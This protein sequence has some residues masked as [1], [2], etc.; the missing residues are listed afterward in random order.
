MLVGGDT[1][2]MTEESTSLH[3]SQSRGHGVTPLRNKDDEGQR[4]RGLIQKVLTETDHQSAAHSGPVQT[5]TD[6]Y[7]PGCYTDLE[8]CHHCIHHL[9]TER[10]VGF[11]RA[12]DW[13][14]GQE[15]PENTHSVTH[16]VS[17]NRPPQSHS[18]QMSVSPS[19][20]KEAVNIGESRGELFEVA[21]E[22]RGE[23]LKGNTKLS[24]QGFKHCHRQCPLQAC[25]LISTAAKHLLDTQT[26]LV[27]Q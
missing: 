5:T 12:T 22:R 6:L 4:L 23:A 26:H 8:V 27:N 1:Q 11:K 15:G 9:F 3:A 14:E 7:R 16:T 19:R 21:V 18:S 13:R 10:R 2:L 20:S 25:S 24:V 17:T